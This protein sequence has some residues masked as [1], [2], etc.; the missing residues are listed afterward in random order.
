MKSRLFKLN[1]LL[2]MSAI[3]AGVFIFC[4]FMGKVPKGVTVDGVSIG[5]KP[6]EEAVALIRS[7]IEKRLSEKTLTV[8]GLQKIYTF[9]FPEIGYRDN[10]REVVKKAKRGKS[11]ST[12]V[13]YYLKGLDE[14]AAEICRNES[15]GRVAPYAEF[16]TY[17]EPFVYHAGSDGA[18]AD[19]I[20]LK[21]DIRACLNSNFETVKL[22]V[23]KIPRGGSLS[24]LK[25]KTRLLSSFTTYFDSTNCD[26]A[27]NIALAASS[28]NGTV[29]GA[30]EEFSF[31]NIVGIRT[32]ER[33]YR[34]AKII[35]RGEFVEGIGGGVCQVSTTLFNAAILSGLDISEYHAH[36]LQVG[37]VP[38]SFDAMVS[39][40]AFDL[41]FVNNNACPVYIRAETGEGFVRF[42][43][44][45]KSDGCVYSYSSTVTEEVEAPEEL[46][47]DP[48]AVREGKNGLK[49]EGYL[50]VVKSGV[51]TTRLFRKDS[52]APIKRVVCENNL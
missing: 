21:S 13:T 14:I 17:G 23:R 43:I 9:A 45:G 41:K 20:K 26:R 11:Y 29:L 7:D 5:G 2:I 34:A 39:G 35:E 33:G 27:H 48:A 15:F 32:K 50:T 52:Y 51:A 18:V 38:P 10:A 49:S 36:S 42:K 46:T 6:R 3:V 19:L 30:G 22:S 8:C 24:E 1:I 25:L 31:N 40:S 44:Y 12:T 16:Q 47:E 37:Y 4:G 28:I